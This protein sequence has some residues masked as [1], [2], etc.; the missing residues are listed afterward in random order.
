M[1]E[2]ELFRVACE[3]FHQEPTDEFRIDV[4]NHI[5][6]GQL[7]VVN[8]NGRVE[9]FAMIQRFPKL[10]TVYLAGLVK[11]KRA[12]KEI[13][14]KIVKE[15]IDREKPDKVVTRTQ[16]DRVVEIMTEVCQTVVPL[17]RPPTNEELVLIRYMGLY[18]SALDP[19]T[20][21][22]RDHYGRPM[23]LSGE[24]KRSTNRRVTAVTEKLNYEAG[25][26]LLLVG[27]RR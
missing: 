21:I 23:I 12:P 24:R 22:V 25:D 18:S 2:S 15:F 16:N 5:R 14:G 8:H 10:H 9:G 1:L 20:L 4:A 17:D 26:A 13:I 3:G 11:T 19:S 27:Y 6:G 7:Y